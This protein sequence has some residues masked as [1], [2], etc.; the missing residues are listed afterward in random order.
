MHCPLLFLNINKFSSQIL[1]ID[2]VFWVIP[3]KILPLPVLHLQSIS[4]LSCQLLPR[5]LTSTSLVP[6]Y[7]VLI[8]GLQILVPLFIVIH[9][10]H[11]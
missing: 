4:S 1:E 11:S 9:I 10:Q 8:L 2:C 3:L 7:H 6:L 5:S